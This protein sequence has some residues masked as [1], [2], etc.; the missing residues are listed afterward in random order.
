V[1]ITV[2]GRPGTAV[3]QG[4][5]VVVALVSEKTPDLPKGLPEPPAGTRYTVFVARKPWA[6]VAEALGADPE[7]A[8][9]IEGYAALDPRVEGIV[10]YATSAT[11]KRLQAAKRVTTAAT[12]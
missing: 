11:T 5:A 1:K 9:I 12:P 4:Q 7:D 2:I 10:V 3:E 6:K 8:A